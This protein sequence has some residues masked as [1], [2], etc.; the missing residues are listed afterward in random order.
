MQTVKIRLD[1]SG[2]LPM[3]EKILKT[4]YA[5]AMD[6]EP[7]E[8][9]M[10]ITP[11]GTVELQVT[12]KPYMIHAKINVPLYG[13]LWVMADNLGQGY[14]GDFVD[15]VSEATRTYLAHAQRFAREF[16]SARKP[17]VI[18]GRLSSWS[19]WPTAAP[20]PRTTA[21]TPCPTPSMRR[22]AHWWNGP[23]RRCLPRPA[24]T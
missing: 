24:R 5:S 22:R 19:T 1:G 17:M 12:H 11:D 23:G 3:P 16:S 10:R 2:G 8:R 7:D 18:C 15:F 13:N 9:R 21:S 4:V 20:I 6:F 14:T